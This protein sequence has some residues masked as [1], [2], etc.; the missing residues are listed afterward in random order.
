MPRSIS[1]PT[2]RKKTIQ[3]QSYAVVTLSDSVT[4]ERR[5]YGLGLYD[6]PVARE[7]YIRLITE[8][9]RQ[10]SGLVDDSASTSYRYAAL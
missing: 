10:P 6:D 4:R 9:V 1:I 5:D 7:K 3:K 2:Y 8:A